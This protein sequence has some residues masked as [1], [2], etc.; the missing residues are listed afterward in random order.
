MSLV[1]RDTG[2]G[3]DGPPGDGV[4]QYRQ[5]TAELQFKRAACFA[6]QDLLSVETLRTTT[7]EETQHNTSTSSVIIV[8]CRALTLKA[9]VSD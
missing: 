4:D 9:L 1:I 8:D 2:A 7:H 6:G 5:H 3:D